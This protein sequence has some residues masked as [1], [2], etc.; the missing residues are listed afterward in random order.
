[1]LMEQV[2]ARSCSWDC[3]FAWYAVARNSVF[4]LWAYGALLMVGDAAEFGF[5][6]GFDLASFLDDPMDQPL[7]NPGCPLALRS[8]LMEQFWLGP[9]HG[10]LYFCLVCCGKELCVFAVDIWVSR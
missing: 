9:A 3:I 6:A 1:M 10:T 5:A 2:L 4:L 7:G 8:M